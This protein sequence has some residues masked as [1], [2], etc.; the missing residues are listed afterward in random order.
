MIRFKAI[1]VRVVKELLRDKRTLALM[2][3]APIL[4]LTMLYFV[5]DSNTDTHLTIGVDETVPSSIIESFPEKSVKIKKYTESR[6]KEEIIKEE[7]LDAFVTLTDATFLVTYKN[8]DP[9]VTAQTRILFGNA[10][11]GSKLH[12][13]VEEVQ[14]FAQQTGTTIQQESFKVKSEYVYGTKNSTFFDKILPIL[15]GFFV[16]FFVFLISGIALLRERTTGTLERLLATPVKRSEIVFGYLVGYGIFAVIQ[17]LIIVFYSIYLLNLHIEG[18]IWWVLV[19]NI[20]I[21]L[22]ALVMGIFVSTFANSEFQM[23]QFIPLVVL[24]QIFFSG[25]IA[26]DSMAGWVQK[27]GYLFPLSYGGTIL[28]DVMIKGQGFEAI[29]KNLGMLGIFV[30]LFTFLNIKGLKRYRKV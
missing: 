3:V 9:G 2:L 6:N 8:E 12:E 13:L 15:V 30:I 20:S 24:P 7:G 16:F 5:F 10:L 25:I 14:K 18:S 1:V 26:I 29:W 27:L 22:V 17:T 11:T 4:I 23:V 19:T 21:A 28:T